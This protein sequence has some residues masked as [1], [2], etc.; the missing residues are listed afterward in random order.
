MLKLHTAQ[1]L[2]TM[3]ERPRGQVEETDESW[4]V[5]KRSSVNS[6]AGTL[7]TKQ[8]RTNATENFMYLCSVGHY[9]KWN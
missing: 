6:R 7:E 3:I 4:Q 5:L 2:K 8:K 9:L 1:V